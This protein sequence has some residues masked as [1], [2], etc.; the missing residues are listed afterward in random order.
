M[1]EISQ[2][3]AKDFVRIAKEFNSTRWLQYTKILKNAIRK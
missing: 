2:N 1:E 3:S